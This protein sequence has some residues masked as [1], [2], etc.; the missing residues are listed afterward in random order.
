MRQRNKRWLATTAALAAVAVLAGC[1]GSSAGDPNKESDEPVTITF[2][3]W[4]NDARAEATQKVIDAFEKK[5]KN[6]TV[7]P[8]S[9]D[10]PSYWDKISTQFTGGNAP[11][12]ITMSGSYPAEYADDGALLDLAKVKDTIDTSDFMPGTLELGQ[13]EGKQYT[14]T[15][16]LN[17][18]SIVADPA[19]FEAAG[20]EMPDDET[21]TWDDFADIAAEVTEKS[22]KGTFGTA[23]FANDSFAAVWARQNGEKLFAKDGSKVAMTEKT[24]AKWFELWLDLQ[25]S[26]AS[27]KASQ[28]VEDMVAQPEQTLLGQGKQGLKLSWSNQLSAYANPELKILKLPGESEKAGNWLRSSM[29]Y[30][31]SGKSKHPKEAAMFIDFLVNSTEAGEIIGADRGQSA[32]EKVRAHVQE[33]LTDDQKKEAKYLERVA[34]DKT[35]APLPFPPGSSAVTDILTRQLQEALFE[36]ATPKEAAKALIEETNAKLG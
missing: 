18:L 4:G 27:P 30:A 24:A 26:G 17:A 22:P 33:Q 20:V 23:P 35:K 6:I 31:I 1:S 11:D 5:H 10:F 2:S 28:V 9:S 16:G 12:V 21:W 3:W 34:E 25:K 8:Q 19:V 15:A 36:R 14:I 7:K 13:F 29:E 32:N